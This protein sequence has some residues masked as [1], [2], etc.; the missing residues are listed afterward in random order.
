MEPL[1]DGVGAEQTALDISND[2]AQ[3]P[4]RSGG[5]KAEDL[6]TSKIPALSRREDG[7]DCHYI[8]EIRIAEAHIELLRPSIGSA[9]AAIRVRKTASSGENVDI[10]SS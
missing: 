3:L 5:G 9:A 2:A 6:T 4:D 8:C 7:D 1:A 10:S